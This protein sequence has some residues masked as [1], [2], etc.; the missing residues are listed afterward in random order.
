V[1]H[2]LRQRCLAQKKP[3]AEFE[4]SPLLL[5]SSF[6]SKRIERQLNPSRSQPAQSNDENRTRTV[7]L[8]SD[9][10]FSL[11]ITSYFYFVFES[12]HFIRFFLSGLTQA[13]THERTK[14]RGGPIAGGI[15]REVIWKLGKKGTQKCSVQHLSFSCILHVLSVNPRANPGGG[16]RLLLPRV[17]RHINFCVNA[18][19]RKDNT[20]LQH[21]ILAVPKFC[22]R[23]V[24]DRSARHI[25]RLF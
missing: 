14:P 16:D 18:R 25:C 3:R 2:C 13:L 21:D 10:S 7:D 24:Q 12:F 15:W 6:P 9:F 4:V 8:F 20:R 19:V 17:E 22:K 5:T 11:S 23:Q 1:R